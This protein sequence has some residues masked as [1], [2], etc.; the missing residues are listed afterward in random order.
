[1]K[2]HAALLLV[3]FL[4]FGA[5]AATLDDELQAAQNL[6]WQKR[7]AEAEA[8]YRRILDRNPGSRAAVLG[9][10]QVLLWEERY[11][12]AATV[13]RGRLREMPSD[14]DARKGL[15]TAEYWSGDYRAAQRDFNAVVAARPGDADARKALA[16][17][18]ATT[19]P[20]IASDNAFVTDDQ[21]LRRTTV[22]GSATVFS[23]P[24]TKWTGT[25]G[26]HVMN[27]PDSGLGSAK[28]P[29]ASIALDTAVPAPHLRLR[30]TL[31]V[32]RFPDGTTKPLGAIG[33]AREWSQASIAVE[34]ERHEILHAASAMRGHPSGT[35]STLE[36]NRDT[37]AGSSAAAV[38]LIHY[39]DRNRGR[40]AEAYHLV[41]IARGARVSV[42]AGASASYR[43]TG[44]SRFRL[45]GASASRAGDGFAYSYD[46]RYDPYWTP[47][48][49]VELRGIVAAR[50]DIGR[51][52]VRLHGDGGWA[53]D[54]YPVFG[55]A[56]WTAPLP[57]LFAAPVEAPRTFHPWRA[58][59][60][61]DV[62]VRGA[63]IA[64][65]G[66]ERQTTVFYRATA[67]RVGL[68]G[69]L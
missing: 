25:A 26:S 12:E 65:I 61:L 2:R 49:L 31:R 58:S 66:I 29:F 5:Q 6:A 56:S 16:E 10:G 52:T 30:G 8:F 42:S 4:A 39:F 51:A 69:R 19:A 14:I 1:M 23:D 60:D 28:A 57:P 48:D 47:R 45:I 33:L 24:L 15:A 68:H 55:P 21:P 17:I 13:Y 64:T 67:F 46:A 20:V 11:G 59:A 27:A 18:A 35:T 3:F 36:W 63:F 54:R 7:F 34:I 53:H 37:D 50:I 22:Q 32:L 62:P 41:R 40:A 38:H 9:L 43:D 44:A